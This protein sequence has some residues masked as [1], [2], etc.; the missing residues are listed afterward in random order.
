M[1]Y[2]IRRA[3]TEDVRPALELALRVFMEFETPCYGDGA[4]E[5]FKA[6][7]VENKGYIKSY[8]S[9]ERFTE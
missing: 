2:V 8:I 1:N 5:K 7:C 3:S 9:G 4:A 6:D